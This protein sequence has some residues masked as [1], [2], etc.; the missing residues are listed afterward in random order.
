[1]TDAARKKVFLGGT[2]GNGAAPNWQAVAAQAFFGQPVYVMNPRREAWDPNASPKV[3][4]EQINWELE[5]QEMADVILYTFCPG[6]PSTIT[7]H[8]LGLFC[9]T[10]KVVVCC[11]KD[12]AHFIHVRVTCAR[13]RVPRFDT[14]AEALASVRTILNVAHTF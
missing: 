12:Y 6:F 11:P 2:I 4:E 8:E 1:M 5:A 9:R 13:F 14:P 3:K 7:L 10:K